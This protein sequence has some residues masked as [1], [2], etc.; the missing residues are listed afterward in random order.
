VDTQQVALIPTCIEC[1]AG[2][3]PS[4]EER[5]LAD[6]TDDE[7]PELAFFRPTCAKREF[8]G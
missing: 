8:G 5:W 2:W 1:K 4:E 6:L 3:L 7:P